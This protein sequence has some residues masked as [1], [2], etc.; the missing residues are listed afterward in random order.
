MTWVKKPYNDKWGKEKRVLKYSK[1]ARNLPLT[2]SID[3]LQCTK[4]Q[5]DVHR[6]HKDCTGQ[7][8]AALMLGAGAA[9]IFQGNRR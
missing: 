2:M 5:M 9:I 3:N 7:T 4:W 8:G 1:G 6:T